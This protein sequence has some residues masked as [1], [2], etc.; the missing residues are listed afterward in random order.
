MSNFDDEASLAEDNKLEPE[1]LTPLLH[2][3]REIEVSMGNL[4]PDKDQTRGLE[5]SDWIAN[6][7]EREREA[8]SERLFNEICQKL[9]LDGFD[10]TRIAE[11]I[12]KVVRGKNTTMPYCNSSEVEAVLVPNG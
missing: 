11:L 2:Q 1:W 5:I 9:Y 8:L 6:K 10:S 12:N 4:L 7:N 3:L